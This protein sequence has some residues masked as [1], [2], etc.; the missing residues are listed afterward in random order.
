[1]YTERNELVRRMNIAKNEVFC[2]P[3]NPNESR[4]GV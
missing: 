2:E 3:V 1:M 4:D